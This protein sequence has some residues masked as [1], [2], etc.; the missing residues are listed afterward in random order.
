MA[1]RPD[2]S[3]QRRHQIMDAA[4][5]VFSHL[6]FERASMEDIAKQAGISKAALYLYYKSKDAI[7]AKLLQL[8][9]DQAIKQ[10]RPLAAGEGSVASQLMSM[11][12]QLI[13]EMDRMV[14]MQPISLQFYAVAARL[15]EVRQHLRAYFAEYR[16]FMES[17]IRRG[18]A[19]GEFR[20]TVN[21]AEV[22]ITITALYEG[23]G[24]LWIVDPQGAK[25][26]EQVETSMRLLLQA[27]VV[28]PDSPPE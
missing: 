20:P 7:I 22:A 13:R 12:R 26:H 3:D 15:P 25:W 23:L 19:Q 28:T 10:L 9:F 24:L 6:G 11:T 5:D 17:A 8:F 18:I 2:V 16:T 27:L 14:A 1:P 4:L 21:P